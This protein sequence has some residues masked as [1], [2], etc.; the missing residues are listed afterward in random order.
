M[1][2]QIEFVFFLQTELESK[3]RVIDNLLETLTVC[4]HTQSSML[5]E[6]YFSSQNQKFNST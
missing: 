1:K 6:R 3:Q 5:D 4:L 2:S